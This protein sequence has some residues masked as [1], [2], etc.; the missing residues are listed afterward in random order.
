VQVYFNNIPGF[1]RELGVHITKVKSVNL[2]KWPP[3]YVNYFLKI[4]KSNLTTLDNK[5]A[6]EYWESKLKEDM[7]FVKLQNDESCLQVYIRDKY[8]RKRYAAKG[9]DPMTLII[10]GKDIVV[11]PKERDSTSTSSKEAR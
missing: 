1:H 8:E 5:I 9:K 6:N 4:S 7:D 11:K 2:D 3:G 10:E